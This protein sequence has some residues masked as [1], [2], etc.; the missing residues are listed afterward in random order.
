LRLQA[1]DLFPIVGDPNKIRRI[2]QNLIV[3][4]IKYTEQGGVEVVVEAHEAAWELQIKDTGIGMQ[5]RATPAIAD[6]LQTAT[7][8][9]EER[10]DETPLETLPSESVRVH[11][12]PGEG[13]GLTIVKRLCDLLDSTV[14]VSTSPGHGTTFKILFPR[15]YP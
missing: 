3:N 4:A 2:A 15:A 7:R 9:A 14:A 8:V 1:P 12:T 6:L 11:P 10:A 13:V 5:D